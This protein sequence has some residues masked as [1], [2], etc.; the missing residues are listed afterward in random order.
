M[1]LVQLLI[2]L[3]IFLKIKKKLAFHNGGVRAVYE[4]STD[5]KPPVTH[6]EILYKA[7]RMQYLFRGPTNFSLYKFMDIRNH[8]KQDD[9]VNF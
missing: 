4:D 5:E 7:R 2:D 9:V 1:R 8:P 3:V 6:H